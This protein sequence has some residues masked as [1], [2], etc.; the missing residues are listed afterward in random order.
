MK[1][2]IYSQPPGHWY[3]AYT[4]PATSQRT[5]R[6]CGTGPAGKARAAAFCRS[7]REPAADQPLIVNAK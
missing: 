3:V 4:D 7:L 1:A 2:H 6:D 5:V